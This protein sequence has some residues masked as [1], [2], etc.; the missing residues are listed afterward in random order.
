[1]IQN[2]F[3]V[4]VRLCV[5][6]TISAYRMLYSNLLQLVHD[7]GR[8]ALYSLLLASQRLRHGDLERVLLQQHKSD[9]LLGDKIAFER[10]GNP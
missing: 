10:S 3:H 7:L 6:R 2:Y 8:S 1:M 9:K 5:D 4:H